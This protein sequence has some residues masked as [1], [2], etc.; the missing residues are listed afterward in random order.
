MT[1]QGTARRPAKR[2]LIAGATAAATIAAGALVSS[3]LVAGA[4]AATPVSSTQ[5]QTCKVTLNGV[6]TTVD[7]AERTRTVV[8]GTGGSWAV[9]GFFVRTD[10]ACTFKRVLKVDGRVGYNG[11]SNGLT[12]RQGS[13]TTPS[14]TYTMTES[15]GNSP[16]PATALSYHRVKTGDYWVQDQNSAFYNTLRNSGLGGFLA[17][18]TGSNGSER[19]LDYTTQYAH[20]VVINFNRAPERR[21]VGRG[22]G[23]F[24]HVNGRGAT[25]GCVSITKAG[26]RTLMSYLRSGD[27]ITITA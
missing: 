5:W 21:T 8:N 16:R 11:I 7:K 4:G 17:S 19:L 14:G 18:T 1:E 22:S 2:R 12:R 26:L 23:I 24:L 10:G 6:Q 20:S 3:E 15:F 9:V 27:R 13:G 25:A